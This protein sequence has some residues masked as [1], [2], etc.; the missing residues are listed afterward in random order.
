ME[1]RLKKNTTTEPVEQAHKICY[2]LTKKVVTMDFTVQHREMSLKKFRICK[3]NLPKRFN[4]DGH[5][6]YP[7]P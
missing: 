7:L 5:L 6:L 2:S 1:H 3:Q 4:K